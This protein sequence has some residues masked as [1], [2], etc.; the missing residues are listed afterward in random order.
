M[1]HPASFTLHGSTFECHAEW[2][3]SDNAS[4]WHHENV[5]FVHS[6][7][8]TSD[9]LLRAAGSNFYYATRASNNV[10]CRGLSSRHSCSTC[11]PHCSVHM[12][13]SLQPIHKQPVLYSRVHPCD[14]TVRRNN[15]QHFSKIRRAAP[16]SG[17][18]M[19]FSNRL[20]GRPVLTRCSAIATSRVLKQYEWC[21]NVA[22]DAGIAIWVWCVLC[23]LSTELM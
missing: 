19:L 2:K 20:T 18:H 15:E 9:W 21:E 3:V 8:C 4:T 16:P 13:F 6:T 5:A 14:A 22:G 7:Y 11:R 23:G 1:Q 10:T 12:S 17:V